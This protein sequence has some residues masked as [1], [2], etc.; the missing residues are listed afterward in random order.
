MSKT[1]AHHGHSGGS[2]SG[3][4]SSST[5]IQPTSNN[6][7]RVGDY[8]FFENSSSSSYAIRRIEE[9]NRTSNGNVEARVMCFYRRSEVPS[10]LVAQA[11]KHH[12]GETDPPADADIVDSDDEDAAKDAAERAERTKLKTREVFLSRQVETLPATL[13]RGRY[14]L[15]LNKLT[16]LMHT[17]SIQMLRTFS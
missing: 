12:W 6:M 4:T 11:D 14:S 8:V 10:T 17:S 7:Y 13:I 3:N 1:M 15:H 9:L 2:S 16:G 5:S